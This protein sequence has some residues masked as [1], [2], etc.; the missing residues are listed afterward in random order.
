MDGS[1]GGGMSRQQRPSVCLRDE[2]QLQQGAGAPLREQRLCQG[3]AAT[4]KYRAGV[5]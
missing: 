5:G 2:D 4:W 1:P 3:R